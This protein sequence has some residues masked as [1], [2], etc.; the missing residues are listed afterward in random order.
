MGDSHRRRSMG[1]P[2]P[3]ELQT[4]K[5]GTPYCV[6]LKTRTKEKV[7]R[8][9]LLNQTEKIP[10]FNENGQLKSSL[11][12]WSQHCHNCPWSRGRGSPSQSQSLRHIEPSLNI[13]VYVI[14]YLKL[15]LITDSLFA[16]CNH[17]FTLPEEKKLVSMM[18]DWARVGPRTVCL[19][20]CGHNSSLQWRAVVPVSDPCLMAGL[21]STYYIYR[22]YR[23]ASNCPNQ[24]YVPR[25]GVS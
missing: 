7:S 22:T 8:K 6:V 10:Y 19:F 3:Q 25:V 11:D 15:D 1:Y 18:V 24:Y 23:P 2:S 13:Y 20:H 16:E 9:C 12:W 5:P 4:L 14:N 17:V 21:L